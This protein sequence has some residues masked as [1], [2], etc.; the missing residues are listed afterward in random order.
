[1]GPSLEYHISTLLKPLIDELITRFRGFAGLTAPSQK[2]SALLIFDGHEVRRYLDVHDVRAVRMRAEVVHE[3]VVC[4]VDKEVESVHHFAIVADQRH[5]DSLFD[6]LRY[7]LL[8]SL[9]LLQQL[10]LHLL[11][12]LFEQKLGLAD[13]LL[14]LLQRLLNLIG[15]LQHAHV[16]AVSELVLLLPEK[17]GAHISLLIQLFRLQLHVYEVCVFQQAGKLVQFLLLEHLKLLMQ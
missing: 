15:L 8:R 2:D 3:E 9:L 11:F 16:V 12:R 17:L 14:T 4:V 5:L 1:M 6:H 7:S 13:H 10:D